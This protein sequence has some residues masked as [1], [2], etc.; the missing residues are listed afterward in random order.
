MIARVS[1][2]L[3]VFLVLAP[4]VSLATPKAPTSAPPRVR[5]DLRATILVTGDLVAGQKSRVLVGLK[6]VGSTSAYFWFNEPSW[7]QS[8]GLAPIT[9]TARAREVGGES[10]YVTGTSD[11]V[12]EGADV[13]P[14]PKAVFMLKPAGEMF[15]VV[16]LDIG[17]APAGA[18]RLS[19][20]GV[21][22]KATSDLSCSRAAFYRVHAEATVRVRRE[23]A[24]VK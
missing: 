3:A 15:R 2:S 8:Y 19:V 18:K 11:S 1:L 16:E 7:V 21:L 5:Q 9:S 4:V 14:E 13:C 12:S 6:N 22:V 20:D 17:D 23:P 10:E 24:P